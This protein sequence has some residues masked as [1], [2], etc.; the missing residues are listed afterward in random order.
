MRPDP[1]P[2]TATTDQG[3]ERTV[4]YG[5]L[6]GTDWASRGV[7]GRITALVAACALALLLA[8]AGQALA[9]PDDYAIESVGA[10][11]STAQAGAHPDFTTVIEFAKDEQGIPH[12]TT[13]DI[14]IELPPGLIAN[15]THIPPCAIADFINFDCPIESQVGVTT[16]EAYPF[17]A[18]LEPVYLLHSPGKDVPARL[19]FIAGLYPLTFDISV[20]TEDEYGLTANLH[21][22]PGVVFLARAETTLW[23]VPADPSHD[24]ERFGSA[25]EPILCGGPC[26]PNRSNLAPVPFMTN[27]TSCTGLQQVRFKA[28]SYYAPNVT[29]TATAPLPAITGCESVPFE[30]TID[31][32]PTSS[33]ADSATGLTARITV[34]QTGFDHPSGLASAHMA[35]AVVELPEGMSINPSAADGLG[36]CTEDQVGLI[37]ADPVRFNGKPADCPPSSKVGTVRIET[38]VLDVALE[39]SLYLAEQDENPFGSLLAGYMVAQGRGVVIK[40]AANFERDPDTGR[41]TAIFDANPQ[42]PFSELELRFKGGSR[43]V[44]ATPPTCGTYEI[45]SD[46]VP[47][48]AADPAHPA[49][50]EVVTQ[51]SKITIDR[52][53]GGGPCL[54]GD[55]AQPADAAALAERPFEPELK[56]GV[57]NP[58]AGSFTPFVFQLKRQDGDQEILATEVTPPEGV[59]ARLAGIPFCSEADAAAGTCDP[60]SLV[61]HAVVGVGAGHPF[62][63]QGNNAG[64]VYLAG[65]YD[66]DGNGPAERAPLS[67]VI[68]V[69][70]VAGPL[71]LGTVNVR[72][73][74]YVDPTTAQLRVVSDPLPQIL[75]GIPLRMRDIRIVMDRPKFTIAP[76]NCTET[77]VTAKA[78]GSHGAQVDL[79]KR[80]QVGECAS[81]SF[82]PNLT[83]EAL[84]GKQ[85]TKRNAHPGIKANLIVPGADAYSEGA[86]RGTHANIRRVQVTLP[87][88]LF[89]DQSSPALADPCTREEYREGNCP[90]SSRVGRAVA[91]TPLLDEP[92]EGP[93]YLRTG[94]NQLPD[95]VADLDG[96]VDIDLV[97]AVSQ[98]NGRIRNTFQ[99]VPDVPISSFELRIEGGARGMLVNANTG[100]GLCGKGRRSIDVSMRA[101]NNRSHAY[102]TQ[103]KAACGSAKAARAQRRAKALRRKAR[104]LRRAG[105]HARAERLERR[106][107]RLLARVS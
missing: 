61:G 21:G 54:A 36:A 34:P 43:G 38:P 29:H 89:L 97:G 65:P 91:H 104:T 107:R 48:S 10:S 23:G 84:G 25:L 72:A 70:A 83:F 1:T 92:L 67:L 74:V 28:R 16:I 9:A 33:E 31:V 99:L 57:Q 32:R 8:H 66:P 58:V 55:P 101:H 68:S 13:R 73:A 60:D 22:L 87:K 80:F 46:L 51:V 98:A 53:P 30:P 26:Q 24:A 63:L 56:A 4:L 88:G 40:V 15:P 102:T 50:E 37:S 12:T 95:L 94:D 106:A 6:F 64:R 76:T 3:K 44:L 7:L 90:A 42:Q 14:E 75:E 93:V 17:S 35:S 62:Y 86:G 82:R 100:K 77:K 96:L 39:G 27:P 49:D 79:A 19:G 81:L 5:S 78:T 47:W 103:M 105:H 18:F 52:G 41:I 20:R 85:A 59:T 71:D 45:T 11:I 69:P 2:A